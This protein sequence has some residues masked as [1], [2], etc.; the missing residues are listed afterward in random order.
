MA[1]VLAPGYV[2]SVSRDT[3]AS[4]NL[5]MPHYGRW[6]LTNV[7]LLWATAGTSFVLRKVQSGDGAVSGVDMTVT[8]PTTG[9]TLTPNEVQ[10]LSNEADLI[11]SKSERIA[12]IVAGNLG[13]TSLVVIDLEYLGD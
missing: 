11:V 8:Y 5:W 2:V 3:S 7:M 1:K 13:A 10:L 6:K 4:S 9:A 12:S